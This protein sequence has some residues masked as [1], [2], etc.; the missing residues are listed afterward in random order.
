MATP[1]SE[2]MAAHFEFARLA[3]QYLV[4]GRFAA[5]AHCLPVAG[6]LLHHSI[7]MFLKCV[8]VK[9]LTLS[10]LKRLG[11]NLN[12]LWARFAELHPDPKHASLV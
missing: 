4:S 6:N 5:L 11:H 2:Q 3:G 12:T 9:S 10:E 7:E 8:L 1:S